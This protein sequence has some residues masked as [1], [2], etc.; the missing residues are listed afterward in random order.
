MPRRLPNL[1]QLRAFEA[2][3]R[4][5]SFKA[6][7]EELNV[8]QA[9][10]SHQIKALEESLGFALFRRTARSVEPLEAAL[11]YADAL[12]AS[13]DGIAE[14]TDALAAAPTGPI[15]LSV[16]PFH[17]NRWLLPELERFAKEHP[18]IVVEPSLAFEMVDLTSGEVDA[19]VRYGHGNWPGLTADLIHEDCL[20]PVATR[21]LI[22]EH[23]LPLSAAEIAKLPLLADPGHADQWEQWL[24][25]A[26]YD[27][28]VPEAKMFAAR[29]YVVDAVMSG[30]GAHLLDVRI[31]ARNVAE[32]QLIYLS[33]T[34]VTSDVAY[35]LVRDAASRPDP[36][37]DV[38]AEWLR[39]AAARIA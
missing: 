18:E 37:L 4:L 31:T 11:S 21:S 24:R 32:G 34:S 17:G 30:H 5:G 27:G 15:R 3:A 2:A 28:P 16:A 33:D 8:T 6:A 23:E 10:V 20:R 1:N 35:W 19:A 29:A 26:G 38:L 7:A 13:F 25:A 36:R 39:A 12:G 22:A 14:A 9:A